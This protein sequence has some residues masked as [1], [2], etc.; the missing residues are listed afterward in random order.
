MAPRKRSS[1]R[2][3]LPGGRS[4]RQLRVGE[5]LRHILSD[6]LRNG[7][8]R[9]PDLADLV[10]TV[11]EVRISPDLKA[12]TAFVMPLAGKDA[13]KI[14]AGLNRASAYIRTEAVKQINLRV[15]PSFSFK[16][17]H[18][19]DEAARVT[20]LLQQPAV[21]ADLDKEPDDE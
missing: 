3:D 9:D 1:S 5:E 18:S 4:Q 11:T 19:F 15:A 14:I 20:K 12:A 13:P 17:D 7:H 21:R 2:E 8:F 6:V 16:L 10:V